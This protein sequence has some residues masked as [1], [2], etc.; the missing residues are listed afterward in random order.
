MKKMFLAGIAGL[1]LGVALCFVFLVRQNPETNST[2]EASQSSSTKT[3]T[4]VENTPDSSAAGT[5]SEE[6]NSGEKAIVE[7]PMEQIRTM[8]I[9]TTT[10]TTAPMRKKFRTTGRIEV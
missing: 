3:A 2:V 7:V 6:G 9:K 4:V 5:Q 8:G 10:V 1:L